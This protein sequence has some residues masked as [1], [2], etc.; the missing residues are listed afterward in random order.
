MKKQFTYLAMAAL[1]AMPFMFTSCDEYHY[2]H[3]EPWYDEPGYGYDDHGGHGQDN[4]ELDLVLMAQYLHANWVGDL[5]ASYTENGVRHNDKFYMEMSF[6]QENS[7]A[8]YGRGQEVSYK[9]N[10]FYKTRTFSWSLDN[11]GNID[12]KYDDGVQMRIYY[13]DLLLST[14]MFT[15]V[16]TG[17]NIEETD[18][19]SFTKATY[20]KPN[21]PVADSGIVFGGKAKK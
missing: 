12:L 3:D 1:M 21:G 20:A 17:I 10:E 4:D 7:Q 19:F 15:G 5:T 13:D 8:T 11:K 18:E 2:W 9:N 14:N 6:D 16:I